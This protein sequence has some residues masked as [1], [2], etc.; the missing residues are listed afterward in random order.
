[1]RIKHVL[2][3][4]AANV[5]R[6]SVYVVKALKV[7]VLEETKRSDRVTISFED[8]VAVLEASESATNSKATNRVDRTQFK[9]SLKWKKLKTATRENKKKSFY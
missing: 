3:S 6:V 2:P 5:N 7:I 1:M 8:E 9:V 4:I